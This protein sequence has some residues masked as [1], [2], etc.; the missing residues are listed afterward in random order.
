MIDKRSHI[1]LSSLWE[2]KMESVDP[3]NQL[4]IGELTF[5]RIMVF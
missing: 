2:V 3:Y 5:G 1:D 4:S